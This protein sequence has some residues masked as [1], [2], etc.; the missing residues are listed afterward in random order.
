MTCD[1]PC[2][3]AC[4]ANLDSKFSS[5]VLPGLQLDVTDAAT[6]AKHS[7]LRILINDVLLTRNWWAHG[8]V[9][10]HEINRA[11]S[12]LVKTLR[13]L[14]SLLPSSRQEHLGIVCDSITCRINECKFAHSRRS[15]PLHRRLSLSSIVVVVFTRNWQRLCH[16]VG[17]PDLD[18]NKL[19][20][21]FPG[22]Q[23]ANLH[24]ILAWKGRNYICHGKCSS[25][26]QALL[27][28]LCSISWLLRSRQPQRSRQSQSPS[29]TESQISVASQEAQTEC[30]R[31][32]QNLLA[33]MRLDNE[34]DVLR[35]VVDSHQDM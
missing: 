17:L 32:I 10:V 23:E 34:Q 25:K 30:D 35:A 22:S 16:A 8:K 11:M 2:R 5:V 24:K 3:Y 31:D 6:D 1:L 4:F 12:S 15:A 18:P 7:K 13:M 27:V 29:L 26:S 20:T 14:E 19:R 28:S 33:H 9:T 21:I